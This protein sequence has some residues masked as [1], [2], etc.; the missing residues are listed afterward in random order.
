MCNIK[1]ALYPSIA[2]SL[3]LYPEHLGISFIQQYTE[4]IDKRIAEKHKSKEER[5]N[6]LIEGFKLILNGTYG[7]S[8]EEKSFLYDPMY[9]F[10]TTIAGQLFISMW[11]ERLVEA[12]PEL[13]FLQVNT[14]GITIK[15]PKT[16]LENIRNANIQLTKET[17]LVIEEAFYSKMCIRDVNNYLS[18]YTDSTREHEHIKLKGDLEIDKEFHKDPSMRIVPLALKEYFVYG[19]PVEETIL[20]HRD[21]FDFCLQLKTNS[22]STPYFKHFDDKGILVSDKLDRTTRYYIAKGKT[23]GTLYKKFND[24]RIIGVNIGYSC[25][26]FNKAFHLD[27]WDDY[28][29]DYNFYITEANK[30]KNV[31]DDKQMYLF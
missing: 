3:Q 14:D 9:T 24:G 19:I 10:K 21:I 29:I 2:K 20:K 16:K 15:I 27:N 26:L 17:G 6:V 13:I 5:D 28:K 25:N 18:V 22:S 4:F 31:I 30:I 8:N 11:A 7:K 23:S 1:F 12:C